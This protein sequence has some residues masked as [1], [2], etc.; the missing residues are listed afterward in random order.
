M[1]E[2]KVTRSTAC[3]FLLASGALLAQHEYTA[4]DIENGGRQYVNN[5]VYCH[6]PE[7]DQIAGISLFRGRFK[8]VVSDD[9][10]VQVI[11]NGVPG[12]GMPAQNM[13]DANARTIDQESYTTHC[14]RNAAHIGT[15]GDTGTEHGFTQAVGQAFDI[16]WLAIDFCA[17]VVLKQFRLLKG[18]DHLHTGGRLK[19]RV[20]HKF[21]RN[22]DN[23]KLRTGHQT[24]T[25]K[26]SPDGET[27][28]P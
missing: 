22:P 12:T 13:N 7:G 26:E 15:H 6:G 11:R 23:Q 3:V 21:R 28:A 4:T 5:C 24:G 18:R 20:H 14:R 8:R 1:V 9:D 27:G 16:R 25:L 19:S 2:S 17:L 10:I